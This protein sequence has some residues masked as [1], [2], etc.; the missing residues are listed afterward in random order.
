VQND[1]CPAHRGGI[2]EDL[3][4]IANGSGDISD[5]SSYKTLPAVEKNATEYHYPRGDEE[6]QQ[7]LYSVGQLISHNGEPD[8]ETLAYA[9][10]AC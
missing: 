2:V 6:R 10:T 1:K 8:M 7:F 9:Q 3:Y 5:R 4:W